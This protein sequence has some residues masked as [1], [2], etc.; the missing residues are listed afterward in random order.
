LRTIVPIARFFADP[1]AQPVV[2]EGLRTFETD[3]RDALHL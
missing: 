2:L 3:A 1:P